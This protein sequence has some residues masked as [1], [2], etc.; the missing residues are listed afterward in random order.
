MVS[1][2]ILSYDVPVRSTLPLVALDDEPV[3]ELVSIFS[4]PW[5]LL[6]S[7]PTGI[8]VGLISKKLLEN[9]NSLEL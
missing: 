7:I 4:I 3:E 8:I 9:Y 2:F 1:V 6:L 5:I